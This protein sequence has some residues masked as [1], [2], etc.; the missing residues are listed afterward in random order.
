VKRKSF[1][2]I[3]KLAAMLSPKKST[4]KKADY[5]T[6]VKNK[7][8]RKTDCL[9]WDESGEKIITNKLFSEKKAS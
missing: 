4:L 8:D 1:R 9:T 2:K 7:S 3:T 6:P 5:K